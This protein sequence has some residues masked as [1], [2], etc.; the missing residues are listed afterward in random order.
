MGRVSTPSDPAPQRIGDAERDRAADLLRDHMAEGRLSKTE[1]DERL[2]KALTARTASDLDPLFSDLPSPRP[3]AAGQAM[4]F[5]PPP[6]SVGASAPTPS[7]SVSVPAGDP[8]SPVPLSPPVMRALM[9]ANAVAWPV[10]IIAATLLGWGNFWWLIFIPVALSGLLGG[11]RNG[12]RTRD[13]DRR[14][15]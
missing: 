15:S 10:V 7:D 12:G 11:N 6:W 1:F 2:D 14:R 4:A 5:T 8:G 9:V 13:R 3:G